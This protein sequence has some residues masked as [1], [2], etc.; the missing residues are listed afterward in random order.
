MFVDYCLG[1]LCLGTWWIWCFIDKLGGIKGFLMELGSH[2]GFKFLTNALFERSF[3]LVRTLVSL[4]VQGIN[5]QKQFLHSSASDEDD[6]SEL[7]SPVVQGAGKML[8][9]VTQKPEP[10]GVQ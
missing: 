8:K 6:F 4:P 5:S 1:I 3:P 10:Y 7:G 9:L 2:D